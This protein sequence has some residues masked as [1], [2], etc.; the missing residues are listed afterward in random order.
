MT[1]FKN[2]ILYMNS[3]S[4]ISFQ[5][6][7]SELMDFVSRNL[8]IKV[9]PIMLRQHMLIMVELLQKVVVTIRIFFC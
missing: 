2:Y 1:E 5:E 4:S 9:L 8:L 7:K 6:P 3:D